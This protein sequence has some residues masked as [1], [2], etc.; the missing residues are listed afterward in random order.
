M[1]TAP[2]PVE[3]GKR[4]ASERILVV[5]LGALG[6][7]LLAEGALRD[8]R[9]Q[10]PNARI[11]VLTRRPFAALLAACPHV[12][13]VIADENAPRWRVDAMWE[14]AHRL[15]SANFTRVVDLQDSSRS[16]FY[17]RYLLG[18]RFRPGAGTDRSQPV[19]SRH[20]AQLHAA[21]IRPSHVKEPRADWLCADVSDTLHQANINRPCIVLLPGSSVRGAT[22]RWP[23]YPEL[24]QHLLDA[25][26]LPVTVPGPLEAAT[27]AHIPGICLQHR[28]GRVLD[29][30][31]LAGVLR[32]AK[33]VVG[34]D[35]GPTHL[36]A[37][38]GVPGLALF[39]GDPAQAARTCMERQ[40]VRV[41]V[42]PGFDGLDAAKVVSELFSESNPK[43][44]S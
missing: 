15:R 17:L 14:L 42:S 3:P 19:L 13:E 27:F 11:S 29:L 5:K 24:A 20:E 40:R 22:K 23:H 37:S 43:T 39:G 12:D 35:S 32:N 6:D 38:L 7:I 31:E 33:A 16:R 4:A 44:S 41:L 10:H 8:I 28:D 26:Q 30:R 34:N 18:H 25:G 2:T 36:A 21:G 9:E 1:H